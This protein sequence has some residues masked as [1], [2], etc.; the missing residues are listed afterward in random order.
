MTTAHPPQAPQAFRGQAIGLPESGRGSLATTGARLGAFVVDSLA[1]TLVAALFVHPH[2]AGHSWS[3]HLPGSWSLIP[4]AVN[5]LVGCT[6]AGG[7][8]GMYLLKLRL[9]RVDQPGSRVGT[10]RVLLRTVLLFL[11]VPAVVFDRDGRGMH[12]RFSDTAV[13][14]A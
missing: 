2:G 6:L 1:S 12:D 9:G 7:T 14:R 11:F 13:V 10:G 8:L 3:D 5:Y 4:L